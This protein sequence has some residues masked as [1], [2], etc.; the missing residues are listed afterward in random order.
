MTFNEWF[1]NFHVTATWD[2]KQITGDSNN[3]ILW[4]P[5]IGFVLPLLRFW[6]YIHFCACCIRSNIGN[7]PALVG[8]LQGQIGSPKPNN[9]FGVTLLF[10]VRKI[11]MLTRTEVHS[12]NKFYHLCGNRHPTK[13]QGNDEFPIRSPY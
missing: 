1:Y 6:N 8:L 2:Q 12:Q 7:L 4:L 13:N 3:E 11:W 9:A 10:L 5:I